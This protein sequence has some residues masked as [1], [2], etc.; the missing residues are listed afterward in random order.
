VSPI[1]ANRRGILALVGCMA[2]Y[3]VS[4]V[5]TKLAAQT[6]PLGEVLA[7]RGLFTI[8]L[9]GL[10]LA[11]LGHARHWRAALS[12]PVMLR[13][14][15]DALS[16]ALYVAA[17]IH[18]PIAN[19]ASLVML[20]PLLLVALSVAFYAER[21]GWR[22]W[23]AVVVGFV[24]VLCIVKP[25]PAGF[26][27]WAVAGLGAAL[28]G[29][30]RELM[31]RRLD[32]TTPSML[33]V[34]TSVV[35]LTLVGYGIGFGEQWQ[36]MTMRGIAALAVAA[37]FFSLAVYLGVLAFREVEISVVAPFRYTF[38]LWAG[39]A[40][41]AF[42]GELPD[43]WSVAGAGLIVASGLYTLHWDATRHTAPGRHAA[44]RTQAHGK[45]PNAS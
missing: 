14:L 36:A 39:I 6:H 27:A 13:S 45:R 20:A 1:A 12:A 3:A 43:F 25:T 23:S 42:F 44:R 7:A 34:F 10:A 19:A 4:D 5:A 9:V 31:T 35:A 11:T 41:Y 29:A 33:V 28:L 30:L 22:R 18:M 16:S 17:L 37:C 40:G 24:G 8:A 38:L 2:A 15:F 32:P 21:I 26:N